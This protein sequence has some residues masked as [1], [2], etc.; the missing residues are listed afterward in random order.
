MASDSTSPNRCNTVGSWLAWHN[1]IPA[2]YSITYK[3]CLI[4]FGSHQ[5]P[6]LDLTN[7]RL[8]CFVVEREGICATGSQPSWPSFTSALG[9]Y[10]L[11]APLC[12]A[13]LDLPNL[14]SF[15]CQS[16]SHP[17][18][19]MSARCQPHLP[20]DPTQAEQLIWKQRC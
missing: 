14:S 19:K 18:R 8:L 15:K 5:S 17:W 4:C 2:S 16:P 12:V 9:P 20:A 6:V 3:C 11:L 7:G 10:D 1:P 13:N